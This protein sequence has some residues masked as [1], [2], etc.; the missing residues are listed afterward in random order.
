MNLTSSFF[1][2]FSA[3]VHVSRINHDAASSSASQ[4]IRLARQPEWSRLLSGQSQRSGVFA[5]QSRPHVRLTGQSQRGDVLDSQSLLPR[6]VAACLQPANA[7]G[8][9]QIRQGARPTAEIVYVFVTFAEAGGRPAKLQLPRPPL[10]GSSGGP[11]DLHRRAAA[12]LHIAQHPTLCTLR[13]AAGRD[14][15]TSGGRGRHRRSL[16]RRHRLLCATT[17]PEDDGAPAG[18]HRALTGCDVRPVVRVEP[19]ACACVV[20]VYSGL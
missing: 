15:I 18:F 17:V 4:H 19:C 12:P 6:R 10:E 8:V 3:H 9:S 14:T 13:A 2:C 1:V 20:S 11:S 7:G 5:R 16:P